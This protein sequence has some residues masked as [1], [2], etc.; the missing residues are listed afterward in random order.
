MRNEAAADALRRQIEE[1]IFN[2]VLKKW[3]G[4]GALDYEVYL[5][6]RELLALQ[7]PAAQRVH[8]DEL[9][10]QVVHQAQELWLKLAAAELVELIAELDADRCWAASAR[11]ERV[12]RTLRCLAREIGVLETLTPDAYQVIRRSL[13][14]GSGQESPGYNAVRCAGDALAA[15]LARL[16][17]RRG[18][19]LIDV[20]RL[21]A[22]TD[23]LKRVC[24]QLIEIDAAFQG[25]LTAHY[26]LVRRVIGVDR[27]VKALDGFPTQMLAG[28]MLL[29]LVPELWNVRVAMT[30]GWTRAGGYAPGAP[31]DDAA[32]DAAHDAATPV[33]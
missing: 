32:H 3:V 18:V 5:R 6:T 23:E 14:D 25:W 4:S 27:S 8:G 29:P 21:D 11:A 20:Y 15:A 19:A 33:A 28:R 16:L 22:E 9:L 13:G 26:Q 12:V 1:P 24:E 2:R 31:R 7:T 17:E 10:F 30:A